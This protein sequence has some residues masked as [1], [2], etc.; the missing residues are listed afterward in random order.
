RKLVKA[1]FFGHGALFIMISPFSFSPKAQ[2][3]SQHLPETRSQSLPLSDSVLLPGDTA[4]LS[5]TA[6][7][8]DPL[9][10]IQLNSAAIRYVKQFLKTNTEDLEAAEKRSQPYFR[11]IEPIL[12]K[13]GLPVELK[14]L[15]VVESQLIPNAVSHVGAKGPWQLMPTTARD[16]G[17]KV[18]R[19][20]DERTYYYKSTVAAAKH[21][22]DL[23][24]EFGDWLLVVA[25]YNSGSGPIY[26]A[27]KRSGSRNFWRLQN[28]LPAE[29]RNHVKRFIGTHCYFQ[30]ENSLTML[31]KSETKSYLKAVSDFKVRKSLALDEHTIIAVR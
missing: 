8:A 13:Y 11:I 14:Y 1:G 4:V 23:Y 6:P 16:L 22:R 12:E 27:I 20:H 26:K 15:A 9:P 21:L 31:T 5:A 3:V 28:F 18:S 2:P 7:S 24:T 17:L 19:K 25:A 29:T 10:S 30:E